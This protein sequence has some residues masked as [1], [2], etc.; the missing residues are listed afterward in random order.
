MGLPGPI[1]WAGGPRW[2]SL[3]GAQGASQFDRV[4]GLG[5]MLDR[6]IFMRMTRGGS[7]QA[8]RLW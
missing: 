3:G 7:G 4:G 6:V 5:M 2:A 1:W 8:R